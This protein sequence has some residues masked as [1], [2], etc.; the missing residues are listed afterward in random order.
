M[1]YN[2]LTPTNEA[3]VEN[4]ELYPHTLS[5]DKPDGEKISGIIRN[6][7]QSEDEYYMMFSLCGE[8]V[9]FSVD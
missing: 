5:Y 1:G 9:E 4:E 6:D 3:F 8:D 7:E 2:I